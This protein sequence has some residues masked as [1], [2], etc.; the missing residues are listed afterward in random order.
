MRYEDFVGKTRNFALFGNELLT[1]LDAKRERLA[2]QIN[3]WLQK[4]QLIRLK[5][6]LY[7]LPQERRE[8]SFSMEW[9]ANT[10]Y[11]PSYLSLEFVLSRYDLIPERVSLW[12]SVST[13]KTKEFK[14]PLGRFVYHHLKSEF[15]FG[16]EELKDE[17]GRSILMARP[18]KAILDLLYLKKG[19]EPSEEFFEENLRLQQR[20]QLKKKM[21]KEYAR[22]FRSQ[23]L[24][25]AARLLVKMHS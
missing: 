10:L 3:R 15:F 6:G 13:R 21:L 4:G 11:S 25:A 7:T 12:T 19:V 14:N 24:E 22:R 5:R 8:V 1:L 2:L 20:D 23:K 17:F 9:L 18:E 16:F